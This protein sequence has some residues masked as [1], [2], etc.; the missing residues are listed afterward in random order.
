MPGKTKRWKSE[1][2][3]KAEGGRAITVILPP[4]LFKSIGYEAVDRGVPR[5]VCAREIIRA[6]LAHRLERDAEGAAS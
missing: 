2:D 1:A 3:A 6:A 5:A 4:D